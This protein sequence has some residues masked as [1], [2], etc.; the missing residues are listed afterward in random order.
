M[1][2]ALTCSL[3]VIVKLI[4]RDASPSINAFIFT[5]HGPDAKRNVLP[6]NVIS[7]KASSSFVI[8][9]IVIALASD[10][11]LNDISALA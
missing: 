4:F 8:L 5:S 7:L 2:E 9:L 3:A 6:V 11:G 10:V 1:V